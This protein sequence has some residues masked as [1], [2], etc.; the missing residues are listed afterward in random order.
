M[1]ISVT[2]QYSTNQT[3]GLTELLV[4]GAHTQMENSKMLEEQ[5]VAKDQRIAT[6]EGKLDIYIFPTRRCSQQQD[7]DARGAD[8]IIRRGSGNITDGR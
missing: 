2:T 6:Q 1:Q 8:Y 7:Q 4:M 3:I 5:H